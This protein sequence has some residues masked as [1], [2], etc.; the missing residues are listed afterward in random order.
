MTE[1]N[2][3]FHLRAALSHLENALNQSIRSV[4]ENDGAKKEIGLKWEQFLGQ[5][6]GQVREKGKKSR[7]NVLGWI[8]FP[9]I[10]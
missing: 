7:I 5:F 9:R 10:R 4:L 6:M 1:Q 2:V 8:N 3:D